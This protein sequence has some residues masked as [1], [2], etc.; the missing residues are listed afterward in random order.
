MSRW[1]GRAAESLRDLIFSGRAKPSSIVSHRLP[2]AEAPMAYDE[3]D[4]RAS[5]YTMVVLKLQ[6]QKAA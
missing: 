6:L 3:F 1:R 4:R 2:L 5:G